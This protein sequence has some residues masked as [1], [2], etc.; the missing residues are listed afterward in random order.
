MNFS[1]QNVLPAMIGVIHLLYRREK[2]AK[3]KR[4][5]PR[6]MNE[7]RFDC[8]YYLLFIYLFTH[9][10]MRRQRKTNLEA[11]TLIKFSPALRCTEGT[12]SHSIILEYLSPL[13]S[14]ITPSI[15]PVETLLMTITEKLQ[16]K[17]II[18]LMA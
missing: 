18:S 13:L 15:R 11:I 8:Y 17:R 7:V 12:R 5:F 16:V 1:L 2:P 3:L 6:A 14:L 4:V 9:S 10:Q